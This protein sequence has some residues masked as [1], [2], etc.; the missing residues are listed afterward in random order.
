M[1]LLVL[2]FLLGLAAPAALAQQKGHQIKVHIK[3]FEEKN[4]LLGYYYGDK[5]YIRDTAFIESDGWAYFE[6]EEA[7]AP[8]IYLLILPPDN[9]FIQVLIDSQNQWISLETTMPIEDATRHMKVK[10]NGDN[11]LFFD[12]LRFLDGKR[13]EVES[14]NQELE[15]AEADSAK[16]KRL[17]EKLTA[18][19][20]AV[21]AYQTDVIRKHPSSMTAAVIRANRPLDDIP[22]FE[23]LEKA[24][25]DLQTFRWMRD[26]WFDNLPPGDPRMLRTPFLFQKIDHYVNKMTLQHPDSIAVAVDR[27]LELASPSE[28][29]FK[30]YLI[31]FLNYYA[32]SNFVGMDAVYVH[33]GQQYYAKGLAP[34]TDQESLDK[35]IENANKLAPLLI[36]KTA[37][38]IQMQTRDGQAISLHGFQAPYTVLFFWDPDCGHCKKSMPDMVRF[39][40][41]FK[42]KG[43]AVF[44]V[45]TKLMTRDSEGNLSSKEVDSCWST[46]EEKEM[47]V[48]FN[49]VDPYHRSRYKSVYDI[50]STP[51]IYILDQDKKILS[52]RIGAEQLADVMDQIMEIQAKE[53]EAGH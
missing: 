30:F 22:S 50:R 42:E 47:D 53:K 33:I 40:K 45:C 17:K 49:T 35:I 15:S 1:R 26:H 43:V 9:Q 46:I 44:A 39:A 38:D 36:G 11:Q 21:S 19:D 2:L 13:R 20:E 31:H 51:Q 10:D 8:G 37:P 27:V 29:T 14:I 48:F 24:E 52:K 6:G 25:K 18:V 41:D 34:W 5:Q 23:G 32:K 3:G 28:E 16:S 7:L 12:Y 4:L